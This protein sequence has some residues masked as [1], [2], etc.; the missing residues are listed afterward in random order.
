MMLSPGPQT[1]SGQEPL[2]EHHP[3]SAGDTPPVPRMSR[4]C[5]DP[6][7]RTPSV[8]IGVLMKVVAF[9]QDDRR[10]P[11][12]NSTELRSEVTH[13]KQIGKN[14]VL[15]Q[16]QGSFPPGIRRPPPRHQCPLTWRGED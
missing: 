13:W 11:L 5:L 6:A 16:K 12:N 15:P 7:D 9:E 10:T 1:N 2:Q 8:S 4:P 14:L 3:G